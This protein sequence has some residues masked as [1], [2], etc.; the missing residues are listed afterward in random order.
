LEKENNMKTLIAVVVLSLL[1]QLAV[2]Q[3]NFEGKIVYKLA[4]L[5]GDT[6]VTVYFGNERLKAEINSTDSIDNNDDDLLIDFANGI[7]HFMN[8]RKKTYRT[9][10]IAG[11]KMQRLP[12][13]KYLPEKNKKI[14]GYNCSAYEMADTSNNDFK[15]GVSFSVFYADSLFYSVKQDY[16]N[17]EM[18]P[19]FTNGKTICMGIEVKQKNDSQKSA[20]GLI[21]IL[22]TAEKIPDSIFS[23]SDYDLDA[24]TIINT[25]S[26]EDSVKQA[27]DS[28]VKDIIARVKQIENGKKKTHKKSPSKNTHNQPTKS[29]AIKPKE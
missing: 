27:V 24:I 13:I 11:T 2:A 19:L 21:P 22:I 7:V 25:P 18:T 1:S 26:L 16:V 6:Q 29:P 10:S 14:L 3:K 28:S 23:L 17:I 8:R 4:S 5:F 12:S 15:N 9:D 20:F